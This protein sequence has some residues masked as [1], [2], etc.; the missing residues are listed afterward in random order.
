LAALELAQEEVGRLRQVEVSLRADANGV[1]TQRD[2]VLADS[3]I[4]AGDDEE[5]L[6]ELGRLRSRGELY[7]RKIA[8]VSR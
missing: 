5:A 7:E 8:D 4:A 1:A 3:V 6:E 2:K